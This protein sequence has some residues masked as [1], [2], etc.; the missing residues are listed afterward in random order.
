MADYYP[1]RLVKTVDLPAGGKPYIFAY[2]PH[3]V[4]GVGACATLL[5]NPTD[6]D[7]KFPGI[8]RRIATLSV[9]FLVPIFRDWLL[10]MGFISASKSSLRKVLQRNESIVLLPGGAPEALLANPKTIELSLQRRKGFIKLAIEAN[11][12]LVPV[13]GFGE[14]QVFSMYNPQKGSL[15]YTLQQEICRVLSFSTPIL[16]SPFPRPTPI[17]VVVGK[18]VEFDSTK[19]IEQCHAQYVKAVQDLYNQHKKAYDHDHIPLSIQ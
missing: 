17:H 14:T 15:I 8:P 10:L 7:L 3:G 9:I 12:S 6:F 19:S 16:L 13:L 18:P 2:H 4:I 1:V 5:T 11:A